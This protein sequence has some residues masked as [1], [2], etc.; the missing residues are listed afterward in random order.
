MRWRIRKFAAGPRGLASS[1]H[2]SAHETQ[3]SKPPQQPTHRLPFKKPSSYHRN[4]RSIVNRVQVSRSR[5]KSTT[6]SRKDVYKSYQPTYQPQS[7]SKP[8]KQV[9]FALPTKSSIDRAPK[10]YPKS[11][12][13]TDTRRSSYP[14]ER[15]SR[16]S[17]VAGPLYVAAGLATLAQATQSGKESSS[18]RKEP[19]R[20]ERPPP[21]QPPAPRREVR[22]SGRQPYTTWSSRPKTQ[23]DRKVDLGE[24]DWAKV[25]KKTI[26]GWY[27]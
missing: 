3:R 26:F 4:K 13:Y 15:S 2:A 27:R 9:R 16:S 23:S 8:K 5:S 11:P 22:S 12:Q 7:Q 19:R 1:Q 25:H 24:Y 18:R 6:M 20:S 17:K 21:P 14:N 10:S